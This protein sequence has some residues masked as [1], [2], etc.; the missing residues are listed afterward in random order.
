[1]PRSATLLTLLTS[2]SVA[3]IA[4]AQ[5]QTLE[6]LRSLGSDDLAITPDGHF[7]VSRDNALDSRTIVTD[8]IGGTLIFEHIS[9]IGDQGVVG[10]CVDAVAVSNE[11]AITIGRSVVVVDLTQNPPVLLAE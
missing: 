4:S 1:M 10:P 9:T 7:M 3:S 2:I 8:L 6:D 11:R 5:F